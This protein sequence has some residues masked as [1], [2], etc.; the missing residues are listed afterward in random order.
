MEP[1]LDFCFLDVV[2][3]PAIREGVSY[4]FLGHSPG[5][6]PARWL[7]GAEA[8]YEVGPVFLYRRSQALDKKNSILVRERMKET[9]VSNRVESSFQLAKA[10]RIL[11][12]EPD[13]GSAFLRFP[14]GFFNRKGSGVNSPDLFCML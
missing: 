11:H 5:S 3:F 4:L 6:A 7:F 13:A 2:D 1:G 12:Q 10:Q 14:F 8:E 9:T